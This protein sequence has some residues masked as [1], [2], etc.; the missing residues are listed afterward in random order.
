VSQANKEAGK[1]N[2]LA[3]TTAVQAA[4]LRR[5]NL[6]TESRLAE[7]N[8]K[9]EYERTKRVELAASLLPRDFFDQSGAIA[10]LTSFPPMSVVFEFINERE[11]RAMAEQINF[12]FKTLHWTTSRK[13][14][15][16]MFIKEGISIS[17]GADVK[18]FLPLGSPQENKLALLEVYMQK[19]SIGERTAQALC[20]GIKHCG[21]DAE[22]G[23]DAVRFPPTTL[24][25][26]VGA[27]PNHA[28]ETTLKELGPPPSPTPFRGGMAGANR[29]AIPEQKP[30][31]GENRPQ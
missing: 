16:E 7:A 17:V 21:I 18:S 8:Q 31:A 6:A 11:P 23:N 24:L 28:L 14:I 30:D 12:V 22:I 25:I 10:R 1:A 26:V 4:E 19:R 29:E 13:L 3:Q 5:A 9:I 15:N 27:K 2:V 20:D